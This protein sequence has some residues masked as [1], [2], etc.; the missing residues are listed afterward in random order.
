MCLREE[1]GCESSLCDGWWGVWCWCVM[2]VCV[3]GVCVCARC[4]CVCVRWCV[5]WGV[6]WGG[7]WGGCGQSVGDC[8]QVGGAGRS[9]G[10]N[11]SMV[12]GLRRDDGRRSCAVL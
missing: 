5:V 8:V 7:E 4:V 2:C 12:A 6:V 1:A 9:H 10:T 3:R 11:G